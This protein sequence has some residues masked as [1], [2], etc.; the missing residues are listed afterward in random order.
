M[1][2]ALCSN[3]IKKVVRISKCRLFWRPH[4]GPT[5]VGSV[6]G[7]NLLVRP[8]RADQLKI[9]TLNRKACQLQSVLGVVWKVWFVL[10]KNNYTTEKNKHICQIVGPRSSF[11]T[12]G[13]PQLVPAPQPTPRLVGSAHTVP[14]SV[15]TGVYLSGV[16]RP[17]LEPKNL[18]PSNA[19]VNYRCTSTFSIAFMAK[20][21]KNRLFFL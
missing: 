16:K 19:A 12:A 8:E 1:I 10:S 17:Q 5:I 6:P 7:K 11:R 4:T 18:H 9:F 20:P 21:A 14:Y 13:P 3:D 2:E 15:G